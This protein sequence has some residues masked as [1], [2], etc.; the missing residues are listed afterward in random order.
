MR[1]S[2]TR[3]TG[4]RRTACC[5]AGTTP[6]HACDKPAGLES[7]TLTYYRDHVEHR[8]IAGIMTRC[9]QRRVRLEIRKWTMTNGT[10]EIVSDIWLN[11]ANFTLP[12]DFSLFAS[13]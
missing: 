3:H 7:I 2:S 1:K 12:L 13:V 6:D 9:W 5:R 8:F 11:S 4:S 10:R